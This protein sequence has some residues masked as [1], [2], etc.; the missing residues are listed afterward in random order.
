MRGSI[1]ISIVLGLV[2]LEPALP[3]D[4]AAVSATATDFVGRWWPDHAVQRVM[5]HGP[6]ESLWGGQA[7]SVRIELVSPEGHPE[8]MVGEVHP[9]RNFVTSWI[10]PDAYGAKSDPRRIDGAEALQIAQRF[11]AAQ[12][13]NWSDQMLLDAASPSAARSGEPHPWHC[14]WRGE[15]DGT[16]T[17]DRVF[18]SVGSTGEIAG[19][20]A[21]A[22]VVYSLED[23]RVPESRALELVRQFIMQRAHFDMTNVTTS[24][25]LILSHRLAAEEGPVWEVTARRPAPDPDAAE[26]CLVRYVDARTEELITPPFRDVIDRYFFLA[27]LPEG[28]AVHEQ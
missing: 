13:P 25:R 16:A 17:G 24:A 3:L 21:D 20:F 15:D 14:V 2:L 8:E 7:Y 28:E 18:V 5:I 19:Y 4:D 6:E 11:A 26:P 27:G 12:F 9:S 22:A 10:V 1:G 23:V